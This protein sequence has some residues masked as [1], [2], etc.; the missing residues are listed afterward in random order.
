MKALLA[1][2]APNS[3]PKRNTER[4]CGLLAERNHCDL[5]VFPELFLSG[6]STEDLESKAQDLDSPAI[7]RLTDA[8]RENRTALVIGFT[9]KI[10]NDPSTFGNSALCVDTDGE[11]R[12]VYRKTHLFGRAE[13]QAFVQG[14]ELAVIELAGVNVG[15][16]ICFDTEFPESARQLAENGADLFV[17]V[18]SNMDPYAEDHHLASRSRALENRRFHLYVN[19]VGSE[20]GYR[21]VGLSRAIATDGSVIEELGAAEGLVEIEIDPGKEPEPELTDYL[22][23]VRK[24]LTVSVRVPTRGEK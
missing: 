10:D 16:M 19:R 24:D 4:V 18:A 8:C 12:A 20:A 2:L 7:R 15:V 9:E 3:D 21:F 23:H 14:E 1:Q 11:I 17:T 5:A 6:Y 22:R 13:N